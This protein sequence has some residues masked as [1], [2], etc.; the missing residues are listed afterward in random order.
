MSYYYQPLLRASTAG[1]SE[2]I[3][4]GVAYCLEHVV[5]NLPLG[6]TLASHALYSNGSAVPLTAGARRVLNTC[7]RHVAQQ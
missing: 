1:Q 6:A 4:V 5:F 7:V 2:E 3:F